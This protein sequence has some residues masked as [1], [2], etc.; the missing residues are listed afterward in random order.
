[1]FKDMR[2]GFASNSVCEF[3]GGSVGEGWEGWGWGKEWAWGG[4]GGNSEEMSELS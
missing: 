1:M 3:G 4:G 2:S